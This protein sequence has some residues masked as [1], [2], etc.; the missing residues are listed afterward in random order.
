MGALLKLTDA[1]LFLFFL[2]IA[3]A[4]PL[5]NAQTCLPHNLFP[6]VIVDLKNWYSHEYGDYLVA[7]AHYAHFTPAKGE[8]SLSLHARVFEFGQEVETASAS[9]GG[10]FVASYTGFR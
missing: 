9:F 10:D 4:T 5:I 2:V 3:L 1:I 8:G 7:E 6:Q